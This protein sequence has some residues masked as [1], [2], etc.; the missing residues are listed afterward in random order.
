[1]KERISIDES[2]ESVSKTKAKLDNYR[3]P[4]TR[5]V[6]A[7]T[8]RGRYRPRNTGAIKNKSY[9]RPRC[10]QCGR[11][12]IYKRTGKRLR[13]YCSNG[14]KQKY[15]RRNKLLK[16]IERKKQLMMNL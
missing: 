5:G 7:G 9:I 4:E 6:K 16:E 1:M 14:C 13:E 15:Y 12:L 3:P 10:K 2:W 8:K 11:D